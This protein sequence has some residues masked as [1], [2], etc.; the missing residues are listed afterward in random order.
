MLRKQR[1][2]EARTIAENL[3]RSP[4]SAY[5]K[6]EAE[7]ILRAADGLRSGKNI[8]PVLVD[9][10]TPDEAKPIILQRKDLTDEDVARIDLEGEISNLNR[11]IPRAKT[12]ER[13]VVGTIERISCGN[14]SM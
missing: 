12:G 4:V 14:E 3:V 1:V 5:V 9:V 6:T 2:G 11:L 10:W 7:S 8:E 13:Q